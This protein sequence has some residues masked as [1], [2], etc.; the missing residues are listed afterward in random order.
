MK[1]NIFAEDPNRAYPFNLFGYDKTD[2]YFEYSNCPQSKPSPNR[3]F[4]L[5]LPGGQL[6]Q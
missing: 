2:L 5:G 1:V 6:L 4:A 3:Y